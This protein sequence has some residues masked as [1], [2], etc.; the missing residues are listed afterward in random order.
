MREEHITIH[1]KNG[2]HEISR[3]GF[4]RWLCLLEIV[5]KTEEKAKDL[6]INL[7]HYDWIKP[8]DFKRYIRERFKSMEIDLEYE[9]NNN[10]VTLQHFNNIPHTQEYHS[11]TYQKQIF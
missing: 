3:D 11:Q 7:D 1:T 9:E 8:V 10:N 4:I 2:P 6:K 5:E